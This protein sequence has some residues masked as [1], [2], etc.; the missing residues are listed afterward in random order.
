MFS[1]QS[2]IGQVGELVPHGTLSRAILNFR[3]FKNSRETNGEY[4]DIELILIG[5]DYEKRRVFDMIMNPFDMQ[6]SEAA[7]RMG[8]LA[9]T[10]ILE[11][12]GYFDP[13]DEVSYSRYEG[14]GM[15]DILEDIKGRE[16]AIKIKVEPGNNGHA[17][18]NR[19]AEWLT[20]NEKAGNGH[21]DWVKLIKEGKT[22]TNPNGPT[23]TRGPAPAFGGNRTVA[24]GP[25][26]PATPP[27]ASWLGAPGAQPQAS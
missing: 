12:Q 22:H 13:N 25:G 15:L 8:L 7:R 9:L 5:G 2:G 14:A 1:S 16:V 19:V 18:K 4:L 3:G 11:H 21:K 10:R 6:N 17:D 23:A 20:P 26:T 24:G 27:K